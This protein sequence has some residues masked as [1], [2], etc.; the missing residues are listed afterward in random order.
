M[1]EKADP[2][3]LRKWVELLAGRI[4]PRPFSNPEVLKRVSEILCSHLSGLGYNTKCQG[5]HYKGNEYFNCVSAPPD[6]VPLDRVSWPVLVIGAHYDTVS[7]TPGADDNASAVAGLMEAARIF[8]SAPPR[9]L[10][11]VS[12]CLEEPPVFRTKNMGSYH[13]A[14]HLIRYCPFS[15]TLYPLHYASHLAL[16]YHSTHPCPLIHLTKFAT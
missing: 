5:F 1:F 2:Q 11:L 15:N 7:S 16:L 8:S 10:R 6:E 4:G 13:Y 14:S 12:F 9:G 3:N